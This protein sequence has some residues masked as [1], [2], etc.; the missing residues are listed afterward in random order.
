MTP[1][2]LSK[3][4]NTRPIQHDEVILVDTI[5]QLRSFYALSKIVFLGKSLTMKGGHN[6]IEPAFFGNTVLVGPH[7]DNFHD[8]L[9]IFLQNQAVIQIQNEIE[10]ESKMIDLLR[11]PENLVHIGQ[12]AKKVVLNQGGATER[13]LSFIGQILKNDIITRP[14]HEKNDL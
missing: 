7:M 1:I 10:L 9:D 13:I 14:A 12:S 3:I 5:G 4:Q 6:I 11:H 2:T 8:I